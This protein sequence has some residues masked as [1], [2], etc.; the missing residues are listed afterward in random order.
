M[1]HFYLKKTNVFSMCNARDT[2]ITLIESERACRACVIV[3]WLIL[4]DIAYAGTLSRKTCLA[5]CVSGPCLMRVCDKQLQHLRR[6]REPQ[7][8]NAYA[9]VYPLYGIRF[10]ISISP[11]PAKIARR[12]AIKFITLVNELFNVMRTMWDR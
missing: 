1:S 3:G 4:R 10:V 2:L 7:R 12:L 11:L 5:T 8:D 9:Y 6:L